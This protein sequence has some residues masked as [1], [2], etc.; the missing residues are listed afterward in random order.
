[1]T[2]APLIGVLGGAGPVASAA[3]VSTIYERWSGQ[4]EQEAP[5]LILYSDPAIPDRT[6]VLLGQ[7]DRSSL[8]TPLEA[9]LSRLCE[10]GAAQIVICCM[11]LHRWLPDIEPALRARVISMVD[12]MFDLVQGHDGPHLVCCSTGARR[13][14]LFESHP[15][16]AAGRDRLVWP[17]TTDQDAIHA[18]LYQ[19]KR[20]ASSAA[21][22]ARF[23][24]YRQ[25]YGAT[26]CVAA[27]SELHIL[28]WARQQ[29]AADAGAGPDWLDPL[30]AIANEIVRQATSRTFLEQR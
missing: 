14:G 25:R 27:C 5:R 22:N 17:D 16:W 3:F 28:A 12:V 15:A 30:G 6:T 21:L 19:I 7:S 10:L 8:A 29:G 11:T 23:D 1:M 20:G 24:E 13:S 9:T 2:G 18:L 26:T 4:R